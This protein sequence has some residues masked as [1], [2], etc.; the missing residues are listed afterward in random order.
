MIAQTL[1]TITVTPGSATVAPSGT[2]QFGATG[3]DQFSNPM[4]VQPGFTWSVTGGGSVNSSGLYTGPYSAGSATVKAT[5]GSVNGSASVTITGTLPSGW[6]GSDIGSVGV[7]GG[8]SYNSGTYTVNGSGTDI[9]GTA[10]AFQ[11]G[12][13]TLTGDGEIRARVTSQT[14]TNAW[15]KAGVMI[16][17]DSTAGSVNALV[18]LTPGHGFTF[19]SRST[20]SGTTAQ[21]GT[22]ASN[23]APN[24]CAVAPSNAQRHASSPLTCPRVAPPG[25]RWARRTSP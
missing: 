12:S 13:Q 21:S 25:R 15:A 9:G 19:Q 23:A 22:T 17:G 16:R 7:P 10:D 8:T 3:Y 2:Q 6:G 5:S 24:N 4:A 1:T 14:N 18:A 11:F 20:V